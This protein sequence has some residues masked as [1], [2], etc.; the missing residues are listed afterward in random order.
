MMAKL[1]KRTFLPSPQIKHWVARHLV[2][3]YDRSWPST[4]A[5]TTDGC[6]GGSCTEF[7]GGTGGT[8][9]SIASYAGGGIS[10]TLS[11]Y[12]ILGGSCCTICNRGSLGGSRRPG[13]S[14]GIEL[15]SALTTC[16]TRRPGGGERIPD[17]PLV[18][19]G[20]GNGGSGGTGGVMLPYVCAS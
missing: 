15:A 5:S 3:D 13:S 9:K 18:P 8:E 17:E 16:S 2:E 6:N 10:Y 1:Q 19:G 12:D 11:A 7:D 14:T 4:P 20:M